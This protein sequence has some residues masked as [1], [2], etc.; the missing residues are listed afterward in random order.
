MKTL[1]T[2]HKKATINISDH[3]PG[4]V[5][6]EL[7]I[8]LTGIVSIILIGWYFTLDPDSEMA[9]LINHFDW[10]ICAIFMVDF[11]RCLIKAPNKRKYFFAIPSL[12]PT[13]G[14]EFVGWGFLDLAASIPVIEGLRFTRAA[15]ICRVIRLI[16][17]A[18]GIKIIVF[19]LRG[20]KR[21][22]LIVGILSATMIGLIGSTFLVLHSESQVEAGI[23][24]ILRTADDTMWWSLSTVLT[25]GCEVFDP[26]T[27]GGRF[28]AII[29]K[30]LAVTVLA[31]MMGLTCGWVT[32]ILASDET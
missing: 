8:A 9:L 20:D 26:V 1:G 31:A 16:R 32:K 29:L 5:A 24:G 13:P 21:V 12:R 17:L 3:K 18:K 14:A 11:A 25:G 7:F 23:E 6:Y 10:G 30:I 19:A 22:L 15:R 28:G 27:P 4:A 2:I